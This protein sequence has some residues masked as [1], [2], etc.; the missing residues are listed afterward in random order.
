[1]SDDE[2][3]EVG[4]RECKDRHARVGKPR[5]DIGIS[6]TGINF[7]VKLLNDL[8]R[9]VPGSNNPTPAACLEA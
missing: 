8:G 7:A 5:H 4:S 3:A 2:L 6:E 1:L 9:R